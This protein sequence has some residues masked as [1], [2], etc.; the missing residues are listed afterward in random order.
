MDVKKFQD[1]RKAQLADFQL[2]Y[3]ALKLEYSQ[4][5]QAAIAE[6]DDLKQQE[7]IQT[8]LSLNSEMSGEL[9][10][11]LGELN[12]GSGSFD[13]KT[14]DQLTNDLIEYQKQYDEISKGK[15][16]VQTLKVIQ[17]STAQN[18]EQATSMYTMYLVALLT[19]CFLI[20]ILVFRVAVISDI[21]SSVT[22]P[23]TI[24]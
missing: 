5:L 22:S 10:S 18:L 19:L 13:P 11:I 8:I 9:R 14:L 23:S 24:V 4:T 7:L 17:A 16:Q 21:F 3:N 2:K 15:D 20:V 12:K 6:E 1:S